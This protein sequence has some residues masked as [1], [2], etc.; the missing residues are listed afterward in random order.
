MKW[1]DDAP[2]YNAGLHRICQG[3]G[4]SGRLDG[5]QQSFHFCG[6]QGDPDAA[7]RVYVERTAP[8]SPLVPQARRRVAWGSALTWLVVSA[9][10]WLVVLAACGYVA[11]RL[12]EWMVRAAGGW[13]I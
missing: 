1:T 12:M 11:A 8:R 13:V 2:A 6:I 3:L 10:T 9:L 4:C 5:C 7:N